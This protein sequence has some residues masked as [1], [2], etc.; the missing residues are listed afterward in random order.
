MKIE[1]QQQADSQRKH[2]S[3]LQELRNKIERKKH[4]L[5][6]SKYLLSIHTLDSLID[7]LQESL[8]NFEFY[9]TI[10]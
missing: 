7:D 4:K 10:K 2:L 3:E 5:N 6:R 9:I 8:E 1:N